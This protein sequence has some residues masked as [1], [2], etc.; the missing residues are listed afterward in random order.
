MTRL[1]R[2]SVEFA[3]A[4]VFIVGTAAGCSGHYLSWTPRRPA[5]ARAVRVE[6]VVDDL[7]PEKRG[8]RDRRVVGSELG[9]FGIPIQLRHSDE[10]EVTGRV[11]DL[12]A[13]ALGARGVE[14]ARDLEHGERKVAVEIAELWCAPEGNVLHAIARLNVSVLALPSGEPLY[15]DSVLAESFDPRTC[16]RA[17][18]ATL[19]KLGDALTERATAG[20]FHDRLLG[21]PKPDPVP[22]PAPAPIPI[23]APVPVPAPVPAPTAP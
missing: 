23:P 15:R 1:P 19:D 17:L 4:A 16:P 21:L 14:T 20:T 22:V 5:A 12:V 10:R 13:A 18:A 7:R 6:V 3:I 2:S 8:G 11:R 9:S